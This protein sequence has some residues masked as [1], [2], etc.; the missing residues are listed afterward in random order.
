MQEP[1]CRF[2]FE[3]NTDQRNPLIS[4]CPCKGSA[5]YIHRACLYRWI[6]TDLDDIKLKCS[7]CKIPLLEA[8]LP[9]LE[10]VPK[11]GSL[12]D[13]LL[14]SSLG[15]LFAIHY[16]LLFLLT[17]PY[18][19]DHKDF[20]GRYINASQ[21]GLHIVYGSLFFLNA[22][23]KNWREY[24]RVSSKAYSWLLAHHV[25]SLYLMLNGFRPLTIPIGASMNMYW[26]TH[27][28]ALVKVNAGL[29]ERFRAGT[30]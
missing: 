15:I 2:C 1:I 10:I 21:L 7:I 22:R 24:V 5:K 26:I 23:V 19:S 25:L 28:A 13:F 29:I 18:R 9:A 20:I 6:F 27:K 14:G 3:P 16:A 30:P 8:F 11:K 12:V 17:T 4:P